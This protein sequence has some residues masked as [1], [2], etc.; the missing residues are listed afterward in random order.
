[1]ADNPNFAQLMVAMLSNENE[2]RSVAETEYEKIPIKDRGSLLFAHYSNGH[3]D[4]ES[5]SL[6]LVLLRRLISNSYE[7]FFKETQIQKDH[8]H[9]EFLR[10]I[11][12]EMQPILRKRLTDLLAE[13]ARNTIDDQTGKQTWTGV[14]QFLEI[15]ATSEDATFRE[16]GMSLI[17][18]VPNIFG[19]DSPK[20]MAGIKQMFQ[21]SLLYGANSSV[22]TSAVRAYVAF[23]CDNEDNEAI[24]RSLSDLV[25]AVIKVCQHVV[26]TEDDDD[27]PLQCLGDLAATIPKILIPYFKEIFDLCANAVADPEKDDSYRHSSLEVMVSFC[28][29][30]SFMKKKAA[31]TFIPALIQQCLKLMTELD[32][33]LAE[34]LEMDDA[35][36]DLDEETAGIGETSLDRIACAL[37]GKTVLTHALQCI[38]ELLNN[39]NWKYR[40]AGLCALSTIG[41]GCK[42][43]MEPLIQDIA[44]QMVLPKI[45]DPHPRVRYAV[46]NAIGQMCTD[47]APTIQKKCHE[48]IVPSLLTAMSDLST[49]RVAAHA[50]A[51]MV[52]FCE[53]CPKSIISIYLP[54]L[55]EK[56]ESVLSQ[57][58]QQLLANGKK[59]VLEQIITTIAS[60]ADAAQDHFA[61]FYNNLMPPL[62]YIFENAKDDNLKLL[63]GK[64]I[65]CISLIGM[66]VGPTLFEADADHIMQ[67]LLSSGVNFENNDD[68]QISYFI[69]AWARICKILGKGF[70]KYLDLIMPAVLA[71]ADFKPDV[72]IVEGGNAEEE[73]EEWDYLPLDD[74]RSL[75]IKTAGLEDKVTACEMIV[76]FARELKENFANYVER[77]LN[78]FLPLLK[79]VFHDG[80]RSAAAE[81]LPCLLVCAKGFGSQYLQQMWG[82]ILQ[83]YKEAIDRET[84]LEVLS[85]MLNGIADSV[86][87][88]GEAEAGVI[89]D[90]D[91][92]IIYMIIL[93]QLQHFEKRRMEREKKR[94]K[95]DEADDDDQEQINEVLE[96]ET[97]VLARISD[98]NHYLF[99]TRREAMIPYFDRLVGQ[100]AALLDPR[101][102]YQDRQWAICIFDDLIEFGGQASLNYQNIFYEPFVI[103]LADKYPEVRQAAAYGCGIMGQKGGPAYAKHCAQLVQPLIAAIEKPESRSTDEDTTATE[104]AISAIAKILKYNSSGLNANEL[105]PRFIEW[106]PIWNDAEEVPYV[107]DYFC[108]LVEAQHPTLQNDPSRIF[109]IIL[110]AFSHGA[111]EDDSSEEMKTVKARM[112]GIMKHIRMND[113]L[114]QQIMGSLQLNSHQKATLDQ[115]LT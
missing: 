26:E 7:E 66:A 28:E 58:F 71:A 72:A 29:S 96:M 25:P 112:K 22:R 69:S 13:L 98:I 79:F 85:E 31:A 92:E 89:S 11:S 37:G 19:S 65:E 8:F 81:C 86:E 87:N 15:C 63:R 110:H 106:L 45:V 60:V 46:C 108:D 90:Q 82:V 17:E 80:V 34:W 49:P 51:A 14:M 40:H 21:S 62:K 75:G 42:R 88:F 3:F 38:N 48:Q 6:A 114:F 103:A 95:D 97:T 35:E 24:I 100:Y 39:E 73:N 41:E 4:I 102:P 9:S 104:N 76:C 64:T 78:M 10:C 111:F 5:R 107:Y 27:V 16:T 23:V 99:M 94:D 84:D 67:S 59:L 36:E 1:M 56:M 70:A 61:K 74:N 115:I 93:D 54:S 33:D 30:S 113:Q 12:T 47:F 50:A 44:N 109:Q 55:M 77:C 53:D 20:Y 68:P 52:N 32:D 43:K 57:T 91:I 2:I 83:A 101:R 18:N 105:I